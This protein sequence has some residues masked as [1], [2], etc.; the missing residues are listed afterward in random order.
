MTVPYPLAVSVRGAHL[1][2]GTVLGDSPVAESHDERFL[3]FAGADR[4]RR[5]S[6]PVLL[7]RT[8]VP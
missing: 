1:L 6:G 8:G 7:R 4:F 5:Q 2:T 3:V